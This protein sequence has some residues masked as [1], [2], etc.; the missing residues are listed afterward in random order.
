MY[1]L[2]LAAVMLRPP[3]ALET[4]ATESTHCQRYCNTCEN[5]TFEN[6]DY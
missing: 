2:S 4:M 3:H 1:M 5:S 6:Q